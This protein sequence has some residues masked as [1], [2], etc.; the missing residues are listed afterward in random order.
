MRLL[1]VL[2]LFALALVLQAPAWLVAD[3]AA[4][5]TGG[6]LV[7]VGPTGSAWSGGG[8]ALLAPGDA[9]TTPVALGRVR[10]QVERI[11]GDG[12][13]FALEQP[14][15]PQ[16]GAPSLVRVTLGS[17]AG[18]AT[19][20]VRLPASML[21]TLVPLAADWRFGGT[22]TIATDRLAW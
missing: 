22:W 6:R 10:W 5:A 15:V 16:S 4:L 17:N 7:I 18:S 11:G 1:V 21:S 12:L 14:V 20:S 8:D 19:G 9:A 3:R 13:T 2:A